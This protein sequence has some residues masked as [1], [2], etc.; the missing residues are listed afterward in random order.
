[1]EKEEEE[2]T[3]R[4]WKGQDPSSGERD[5]DPLREEGAQTCTPVIGMCMWV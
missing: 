5:G 2:E 1:M 4:V 3:S